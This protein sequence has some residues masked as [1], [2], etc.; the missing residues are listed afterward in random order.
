MQVENAVYPRPDQ[1]QG[2]LAL[3]GTGPIVMLNLLKFRETAD[4]EGADEPPASGRDAYMR[5]GEPMRAVVEAAGGRFIFSSKVDALVIGEV[6]EM[7]D[8][9]AL[10]EYPSRAAFVSIAMSP[11]VAAFSHHRKAGLAGQLLI[12]VSQVPDQANRLP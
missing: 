11:E 2:L 12:Q 3:G 8:V 6:G 9:A 10:V 5:Y 1:I 4:Y 7:W